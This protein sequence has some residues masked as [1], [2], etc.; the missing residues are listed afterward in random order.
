MSVTVLSLRA[1]FFYWAW[2]LVLNSHVFKEN[3]LTSPRFSSELKEIFCEKDIYYPQSVEEV[4][5]IIL[6]ATK[7]SHLVRTVGSGHSPSAS[8][9]GEEENVIKICLDGD[10]RKIH[11]FEVNESKTEGLVTVGA[12]CYLGINPKDRSS[13]LDNSFNK[14]IDDRGFALPILGTI[15]HQTV[16]G[17]IQTSTSGGSNQHGLADVIH[18]FEW[19][20]GLGEIC[21]AEK[22]EANFNAVG[23][24]MGLLGVITHITFKLP[25]K[26][27]V[28]GVEVN[29]NM[30][31]SFLAKDSKG[32]FSKLSK[33]LFEEQEYARLSWF[34]Q[35]Y[36]QR[37]NEWT[38]RST[39]PDAKEIPY[40]HPLEP[41]TYSVLAAG[42]LIIGNQLA[43]IGTELAQRLLGILIRPFVMLG[44]GQE[45]CD[46]WYKTLPNDDQAHFDHL[47]S[48]SFSE[49]WFPRERI[50]DVMHT[51]EELVAANPEAAGN[52]V[53]EIYSAKASP[54]LLSP[55]EGRDVFRV[56]LCWYN[57]N[58]C[59]D[60][61][62]YFG[63][64]WE[65]LLM[66]PGARLHWGKYL[67]NIGEKYGEF[68]FKPEILQNNYP[69]LSEWLQI[70]KKM[71]PKN[72]FV[73]D[74]WDRYL[75]ITQSL[76]MKSS[77]ADVRGTMF[78]KDEVNLGKIS[79]FDFVRR[80]SL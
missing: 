77:L 58:R 1:Q 55:A 21:Y 52:F 26:F 48:L 53:V 4:K 63:F 10:L 60:A 51:I 30:N 71:D 69:K 29:H 39:S 35:K 17:C 33:T 46:V 41:Y 32:N 24:S 75:G 67:P 8:I 74:Y 59:G 56:D 37:V 31:D 73:T 68:E 5:Q 70:R 72:I 47:I 11:S 50:N 57:H 79:P 43:T 42:A 16:A 7:N 22:G 25:Q 9:Y 65:K 44:D 62:R 14:Q 19:V 54:F 76:E 64:F 23:V 38:G 61:N 66:I 45:Y 12:G 6:F 20:N 40:H 28:Q 3:D 34:P 27:F 49:F 36:V 18:A 15:S 80:P 78:T 13:T 2:Q